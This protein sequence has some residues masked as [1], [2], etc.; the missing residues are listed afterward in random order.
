MRIDI[1]LINP[2]DY[3]YTIVGGGPAGISLALKLEEH[4]A[5]VLILEGGG[6]SYSQSSQDVFKGKVIG[7]PWGLYRDLRFPRMRFFGGASNHWGGWC[8]PLDKI[9]FIN[10]PIEKQDLDLYLNE[11][12]NILEIRGNFNEDIKINKFLK[13]IEFQFS[14][15]VNFN[16]KYRKYIEESQLIDIVLNANVVNIQGDSR[17]V[18]Y[19]KVC[20]KSSKSYKF[21][22]NNLIIAC[23]GL[24]NSR[25]ML[26]S[27]S[28]DK[29]LFSGLPLGKGWM[30]HPSFTTGE[31]IAHNGNMVGFAEDISYLFDKKLESAIDPDTYFMQPTELMMKKYNIANAG[32]RLRIYRYKKGVYKTLQ[33][34][35]CI[36]P[37][38]GRKLA[39][40][41]DKK[42]ACSMVIR[43][44]WEQKPREQNRIEL[45]YDNKDIFG[46]P[47]VKLFWHIN[48][49]DKNTPLECMK[50]L[51][52]VF[53]EQDFGRV[54]ISKFLTDNG[55][56]PHNDEVAIGHQMGG[57]SMSY[58]SLE[59]VVDKDLKVFNMDNMWVAGSSVFKNG[60]HANP[61]LTIVQ[62]SLRLGR[63]LIDSRDKEVNKNV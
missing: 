11:A 54:G 28:L 3:D 26:W 25:L 53:I 21:N 13:Q 59:G 17:S 43:I 49:V 7:F 33:N 57:T 9:D 4:G 19:I 35:L 31:A 2:E 30:E 61:T 38:Y 18:K 37:N 32:I 8:R 22:V 24:E 56:F 50:Q 51:G 1:Q 29:K 44:V 63:H 15:P 23:G 45:D 10:F 58:N 20:D 60:G 14:P 48:N 47:R 62:L 52:K 46:V 6:Y 39:S 5:K 55:E 27:R 42:L 12:C 16:K 41:V 40:F 36:A 34:L